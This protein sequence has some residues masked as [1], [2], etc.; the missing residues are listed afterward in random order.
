MGTAR[1]NTET[2]DILIASHSLRG[3]KWVILLKF[4]R[5]LTGP[6]S[7]KRPWGFPELLGKKDR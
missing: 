5:T 2:V 3:K 1:Q 7:H 6:W 4:L